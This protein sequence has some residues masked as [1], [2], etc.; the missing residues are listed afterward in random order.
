MP[1]PLDNIVI[2]ETIG[3]DSY[4][5]PIFS[6]HL[7]GRET[8]FTTVVFNEIPHYISFPVERETRFIETNS[9]QYEVIE[10][11]PRNFQLLEDNGENS[12]VLVIIETNNGFFMDN[13]VILRTHQSSE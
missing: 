12:G 9:V 7:N 2:Q 1:S 6:I 5:R 11:L 10:S 8:F 4:G 13:C 3:L